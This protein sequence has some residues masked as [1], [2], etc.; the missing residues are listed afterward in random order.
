[1]KNTN[2][3]LKLIATFILL[4]VVIAIFGEPAAAQATIQTGSIQGTI[5]DSS[6]AVVPGAK[7]T[8]N[9][10]A[11]GQTV[12]LTGTGT[13]SY[14][15]GALIP[16]EYSVKIEKEGFSTQLLKLT[17]QV[18]VVTAGNTRLQVGQAAQ[19][20]TVEG[21]AVQVNTE[22][23]TL[24]GVLNAQ[25]ID[26]LPING[27]NF[28]DLA[29]LEPGVQIQDGGNFDPTKNG[30]SAVSFGGR[31]GRTSRI[32]VDGIDISDENVGT[33]T[34]NIPAS[35]IQEFGISQSSLDLST[36]LTSSGA[37]NVTTK[38]GSNTIHGGGFYLFRDAAA[39]ANQVT[40]GE[41]FQRHQYG[42]S[43][44]GA[45][46]KN[47]LFYYVDAERTKQ[48][49]NVRVLSGR[50][51]SGG[52]FP[53]G[54]FASPFRE[55]MGIAKLDWQV[56]PN[57]YHL[58][59]RFSYDQNRNVAGFV[60]NTFSPFANV[61]H[62][63]VHAA[64]FDFSTGSY[65]H[66][67]RAG[68]TK[69]RNAIADAV[70]GSSIFNP[71]PAI[72]LTI[73][74]TFPDFTCTRGQEAFCSGP[75]ILAPQ[76][77]FQ[78]DKQLKYDGSKTFRSHIFRYGV[79]VNKI[80]GNAFFSFFGIAPAVNSQ[81][82]DYNPAICM[83]FNGCAGGDTNPLNYPAQFVL[84]GN[85]Q[86]FSTEIPSFGRPAGGLFDTRFS[87][88]VGDTWKVK[89]NLTV[90][91]GLRYVRDTGRSD[92]DL[93]PIPVLNQFAPGLGNRVNQPN[94]NFA[95]Q[96]GIAWDPWKN[97]KTSIRA[98]IGLFYENDIFNNVL[99]DRPGRLQKGL[100]FSTG[101]ACFGG[102]NLP[103]P[104]PGGKS[105]TPDFCGKPIGQVANEIGAAQQQYQQAVAAAGP[106]E[107]L[108]FIGN[109]LAFSPN[110][111]G[112]TFFAPNYKTPRSVQ[113]NIGVQRELRQG[114]VLSVDFVRNVVTHSL[115]FWD[116]NHV[117]D[118]RFLNV[119]NANAA[120]SATNTQFG[121]GAGLP[122]INC[123]I[124]NGA[125]I[126]DYAGNG[127]DS[128]GSLCGGT[129]C[130]AAAFQGVNPN[131]GQGLTNFPSG[132]SVYNALQ[133][134]FRQDINHPLPGIRHANL[135]VSYA[136]SRFAAVGA[137]SNDIDF[138]GGAFD[139]NNPL[140]YFGPGSLDRPHQLS[141]GGVIDLPLGFRASTTAHFNSALPQNLTLPT[142][143]TADIFKNDL[144]GDGTAGDILPGT[145]IGAFGRDVSAG[146]LNNKITGFNNSV[147]G[148]LTPAGQA[149][150]NAGVITAQQL[151]ALG[152]DVQ[153]IKLAPSGNVGLSP[154]KTL[155]A[156]ISWAYRW[157]ERLTLEP[158]VA[159]FNALNFANFDPPN[160]RINGVLDGA[161]TSVNGITGATRFNRIGPGTGVFALGA[162]RVLEFGMRLAF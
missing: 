79:G 98:G 19:E 115:L 128:G 99:F 114:T 132:R 160:Q 21:S 162:P 134:S 34:Q 5:T 24:Q 142:T 150:V 44:G 103:V 100:F 131:V 105:L 92:A 117:G 46:I 122:G 23:A 83:P 39:A 62:A 119:A 41:P 14:S 81:A 7:I 20:V 43:F 153:P 57:N 30:Y 60:P 141:F 129:P 28:I 16:G 127:L 137:A 50:A 104:L 109:T 152:G 29:Q 144:T 145:N 136:Y 31:E 15:S 101:V 47:K 32:E 78:S 86:G 76:Q 85:G 159:M 71:A 107:N 12:Q 9:N 1:M 8:I 63:P 96:L 93:P 59:Y 106:Q 66:S 126:D 61:D 110:I 37:I 40:G 158:S 82:T 121:C 130:A 108:S 143:G 67:I 88:Y 49:V 97:G 118:A 13:G 94:L 140:R 3:L 11:T 148:T 151:V 87:W 70:G 112:V 155:D 73:G 45:F 157:H 10:N 58:F 90:N 35:A 56:R 25:Q 68:Y 36:E 125:T 154:L 38:S 135:I 74:P 80:L 123:A 2:L 95:P 84:M 18:G 51:L 27:R 64:G 139:N 72:T 33:T 26:Q 133:A 42:G 146:S 102:T 17:V 113:M 53:S 48:D 161:P 65:T 149:L 52:S 124:T 91:A 156:K 6:G 4:L 120:I 75:N 116:V 89:P 55:S 77:T 69:F 147:A 111:N 22:Q 138:S 54:S